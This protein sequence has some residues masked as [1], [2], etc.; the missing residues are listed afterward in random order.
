VHGRFPDLIPGGPDD[1]DVDKNGRFV[2]DISADQVGASL[3]QW[4][5]L[6]QEQFL[7]VFPNLKNFPKHTL[8]ILRS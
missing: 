2:P 6:S 1:G 5:G 4:M 3:M 7:S 8:P